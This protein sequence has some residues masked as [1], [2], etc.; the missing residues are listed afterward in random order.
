MKFSHL[1][2][3]ICNSRIANLIRNIGL[4]KSFVIFSFCGSELAGGGC[5]VERLYVDIH[6]Y[7]AVPSVADGVFH[8]RCDVVTFGDGEVGVDFYVHV[9]YGGVSCTTRLQV[10]QVAYSGHTEYHDPDFF[11]FFRWQGAFKQFVD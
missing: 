7:V 3:I 11:D 2:S 6:D 4:N 10:M 1:C 9:Y 5:G 8:A